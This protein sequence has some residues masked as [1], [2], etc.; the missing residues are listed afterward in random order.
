ME[1]PP[2][3]PPPPPPLHCKDIWFVPKMDN[4]LLGIFVGAISF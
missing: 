3:P 4:N 1:P 2:P